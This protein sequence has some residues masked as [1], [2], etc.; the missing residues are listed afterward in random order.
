MECPGEL[1]SGLLEKRTA[2][3]PS[4]LRPGRQAHRL[5]L[6]STPEHARPPEVPFRERDLRHSGDGVQGPQPILLLALEEQCRDP[7]SLGLFEV[8]PLEGKHEKRVQL[9]G[10]PP[11]PADF[12]SPVGAAPGELRSRLHVTLVEAELSEKIKAR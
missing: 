6:A 4:L 8:A 7:F 2:T 10:L 12:A 9:T 11:C 3:L 5:F 1:R